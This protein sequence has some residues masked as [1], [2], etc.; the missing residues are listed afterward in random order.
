MYSGCMTAGGIFALPP[1]AVE[2]TSSGH[3]DVGSSTWQAALS[4]VDTGER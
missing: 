2:P 3:R 4:G 1:T